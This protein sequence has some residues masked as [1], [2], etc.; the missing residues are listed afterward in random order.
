MGT[1]VKVKKIPQRKCIVCSDRTDKKKLMR[2]VKNKDGE[3]FIDPTFKANGRG[4]YICETMECLEKAIKSK[5]LNRAFKTEIDR[6][7]YETLKE[8]LGKIEGE[9]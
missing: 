1:P 6:A 2:I 7:V 8:E 3:I 5:A 4:A 9:N